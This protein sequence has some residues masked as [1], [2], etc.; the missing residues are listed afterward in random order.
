MPAG[1][2]VRD[3]V[4]VGG[5]G[6]W[7]VPAGRLQPA[8]ARGE[9]GRGEV[10]AV[11]GG[12]AGHR[13]GGKEG[14]DEGV[15]QAAAAG[16]GPEVGV[17]DSARRRLSLKPTGPPLSPGRARRRGATGLAGQGSP[18]GVKAGSLP[19]S[20]RRKVK[21]AELG[22]GGL[23]PGRERLLPGRERG[24][25]GRRGRGGGGHGAQR[26]HP[27]GPRARGSRGRA[28]GRGRLERPAPAAQPLSVPGGGR[29]PPAVGFET[30]GGIKSLCLGKTRR[31]RGS[32]LWGETRAAGPHGPAPE[33][34]A[35]EARAPKPSLVSHSRGSPYWP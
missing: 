35:A 10:V 23:L 1:V 12:R 18:R 2:C 24:F 19:C 6:C 15:A 16:R 11:A 21:G 29:P 3:G 14:S 31:S 13:R 7:G 26:R 17:G 20:G 27:R 9:R 4:E 33:R 28:C 5:W 34:C 22:R 30:P 32:V 8:R 25:G